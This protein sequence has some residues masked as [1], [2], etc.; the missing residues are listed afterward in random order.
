MKLHIA[1]ISAIS[2]LCDSGPPYKEEVILNI[3]ENASF[4]GFYMISFTICWVR[5]FG[6]CENN[7]KQLKDKMTMFN[8]NAGS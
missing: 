8:M 5:L 3:S 7:E 4:R 6:K 2:A 1:Q